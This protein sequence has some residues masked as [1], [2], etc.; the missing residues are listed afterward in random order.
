MMQCYTPVPGT[1][2]HTAA[3]WQLVKHR[4]RVLS[5]AVIQT[6]SS[7]F[8][9]C[10]YA[11]ILIDAYL[12]GDCSYTER[13]FTLN[14]YSCRKA[15]TTQFQQVRVYC[16]TKLGPCPLRFPKVQNAPNAG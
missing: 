9:D 15:Q 16:P 4:A 2:G 11:D 10:C 8:Q 12:P 14:C 1:A 3:T 5:F 6:L 7:S 13:Q